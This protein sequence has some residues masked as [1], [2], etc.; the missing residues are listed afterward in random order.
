[1]RFVYLASVVLGV[2]WSAIVL[3]IMGARGSEWSAST[4]YLAGAIAGLAAA[5][6]T[7]WSKIRSDGTERFLDGLATFYVGMFAFWG[8]YVVIERIAICIQFRGWSDFNLHDHLLL[9]VWIV[10]YGTFIWGIL[11]IPLTFLTRWLVWRIYIQKAE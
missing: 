8:S 10:V 7:V 2:I 3:A 6:F 5:K 4:W 1:M 11:L 9:I